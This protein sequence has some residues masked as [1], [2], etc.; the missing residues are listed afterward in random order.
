MIQG[1]Q[2]HDIHSGGDQVLHGGDLLDDII[3]PVCHDE[4]HPVCFHIQVDVLGKD[5]VKRGV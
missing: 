1:I 5:R 3:L 2:D 4:I